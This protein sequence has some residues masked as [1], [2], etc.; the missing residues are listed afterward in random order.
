MNPRLGTTILSRLIGRL[1]SE[2]APFSVTYVV[3]SGSFFVLRHRLIARGFE[4]RNG[5]KAP[6]GRP[7]I[8]QVTVWTGLVDGVADRFEHI[9]DWRW[10]GTLFSWTGRLMGHRSDFGGYVC[11]EY[12]L[13][14]C[15]LRISDGDTRSPSMPGLCQDLGIGLLGERH[16]RRNLHELRRSS[17]IVESV[18]EGSAKGS[19]GSL[20]GPVRCLVDRSGE[21]WAIAKVGLSMDR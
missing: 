16:R 8:A 1:G 15:V 3:R 12:L 7:R 17:L 6:G 13:M 20:R 9:V 18:E 11:S 10:T 2:A 5:G 21:R 14:T 4:S 19:T